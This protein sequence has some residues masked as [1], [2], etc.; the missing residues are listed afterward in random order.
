MDGDSGGPEQLSLPG[1][2]APAIVRRWRRVMAVGCSHGDLVHPQAL[3]DVLEFKRRFQPDIRFE[4]GDFVDTAA[5]RSGAAGTKDEAKS[6]R[7]DE[8]RAHSWLDRYEPN[9]VAFGNHDWRLYELQDHPKGIVSALATEMWGKLVGHVERLGAKWVPYDIED[10]WLSE[11][12]TFWGHGFMYSA[13]AVRDHA[14]MLGGP[15]VMA[16]LHTP[17]Q[18]EGR[19]LRDSTSFCVGALADD[20]KLTYGR[21]RRNSLTHGHGLVYGEMSETES[22]LWLVRSPN[23]EHLHFPPGI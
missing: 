11:G 7:D 19:T 9:R 1:F 23:G 18:V 17:Q 2:G 6:P 14:E 5:F 3:E 10:G 22:H 12:G 16:H 15:V 4:L 20:R 8:A 13:N 21:R